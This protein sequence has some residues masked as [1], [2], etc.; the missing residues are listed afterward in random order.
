MGRRV[1]NYKDPQTGETHWL[2]VGTVR[3]IKLSPQSLVRFK[4]MGNYRSMVEFKLDNIDM[5]K[6]I[7]LTAEYECNNKVYRSE[8]QQIDELEFADHLFAAVNADETIDNADFMN[9]MKQNALEDL[10]GKLLSDGMILDRLELNGAGYVHSKDRKVMTIDGLTISVNNDTTANIQ[11]RNCVGPIALSNLVESDIVFYSLGMDFRINSFHIIEEQDGKVKQV[12]IST[13]EILIEETD[14][15]EYFKPFNLGD[16]SNDEIVD[17]FVINRNEMLDNLFEDT[18][19]AL[20][21]RFAD[22][23]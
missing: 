18:S 20:N 21:D 22:I 12:T 17:E 8:A 11:L 14:A 23:F 2:D 3:Q 10:K 9:E 13:D 7:T 6:V 5:L 1:G 15:E 4:E 19:N 16:L